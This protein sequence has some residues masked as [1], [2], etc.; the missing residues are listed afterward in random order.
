MELL[1][2]PKQGSYYKIT[3][4]YT[5]DE[6]N[7][8]LSDPINCVGYRVYNTVNAGNIDPTRKYITPVT[9]DG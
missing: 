4:R 8:I 2:D 5:D 7:Q 1:E 9:G 6:R 3:I